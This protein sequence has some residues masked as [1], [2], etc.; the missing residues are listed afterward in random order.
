MRDASHRTIT[1]IKADLRAVDRQ[2]RQL[3]AELA[4][5]LLMPSPSAS[6]WKGKA[7]E[8]LRADYEGTTR[9]LRQLAATHKTSAGN[10]VNLA[11]RY[12]WFRR[13]VYEQKAAAASR[14]RPAEHQ[15]HVSP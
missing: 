4:K 6:R 11:D 10:I 7:L 14:V 15:Q 2:R 1:E 9:K 12:G 13:A 8:D 5:V 3:R